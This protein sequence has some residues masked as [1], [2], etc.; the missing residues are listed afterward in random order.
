MGLCRVAVVKAQP[1]MGSVLCTCGSEGVVTQEMKEQLI[2]E[3]LREELPPAKDV[4][5]VEALLESGAVRLVRKA[6]VMEHY[7]TKGLLLPRR[8]DI[9][10]DGFVPTEEALRMVAPEADKE[11]VVVASHG[12]LAP[13]HPDPKCVRRQDLKFIL[14]THE[15]LFMDYTSLHQKD[16]A[17]RRTPE[18]QALFKRALSSMQAIYTNPAWLV[19]RLVDVPGDAENPTPYTERGWCLFETSVAAIGA[20]RAGTVSDGKTSPAIKSPVPMTPETFASKL[21][22]M[23]FA[24][25]ADAPAVIRLYRVVWERVRT[26]KT[27]MTFQN[28]TDKEGKEFLEVVPELKAL[29]KVTMILGQMS[30]GC[31]HTFRKTLMQRRIATDGYF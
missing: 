2:D 3:A 10:E 29:Q 17:G 20:R 31:T 16:S 13:H 18:E 27:E 12:W 9:P 4:D 26:E 28:W 15:A 30:A 21:K 24:S 23:R 8:Q 6:W 19:Y 5:T 25:G 14:G 1:A 11:R 22:T 7:V